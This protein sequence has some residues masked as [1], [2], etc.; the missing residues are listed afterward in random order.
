[1]GGGDALEPDIGDVGS[2]VRGGDPLFERPIT[3]ADGGGPS[4]SVDR[5]VT[6]ESE[7]PRT[8]AFP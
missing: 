8:H 7:H 1:M 6:L 3:G 5:P 4:Q 2:V